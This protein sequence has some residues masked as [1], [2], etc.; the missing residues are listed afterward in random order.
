MTQVVQ[1]LVD[2]E[3][4]FCCVAEWNQVELVCHLVE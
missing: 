4:M 1:Y 2:C 3:A